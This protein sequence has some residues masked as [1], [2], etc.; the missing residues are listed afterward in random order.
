MT[1]AE[2]ED[3][4]SYLLLLHHP[5]HA[6]FKL[7]KV[8]HFKVILQACSMSTLLI[9]AGE[10]KVNELIEKTVLDLSPQRDYFFPESKQRVM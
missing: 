4:N 6:F 3:I 9:L 8:L 10:V 7:P 5:E 1:E 2:K